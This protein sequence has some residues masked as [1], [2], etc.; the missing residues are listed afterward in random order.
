MPTSASSL[1]QQLVDHM[2]LASLR[3]APAGASL[4]S[5]PRDTK[6]SYS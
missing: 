2:D 6:S 4:R 3:D 1:C 5:L